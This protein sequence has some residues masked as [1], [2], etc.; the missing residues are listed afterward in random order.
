MT[1]SSVFFSDDFQIACNKLAKYYLQEFTEINLY[2][3]SGTE[4]KVPLEKL[5]VAMKWIRC[6]KEQIKP[7][8]KVKDPDEKPEESDNICFYTQIFDKVCLSTY[9]ICYAHM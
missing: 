7:S 6:N 8:P 5:Y 4:E 2:S 9:K 1:Y 3:L